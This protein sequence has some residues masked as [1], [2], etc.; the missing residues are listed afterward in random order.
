MKDTQESKVKITKLPS[1]R[2]WWDTTKTK[3]ILKIETEYV[4]EYCQNNLVD[5]VAL[6]R[7]RMLQ[8]DFYC[9][10]RFKCEYCGAG[11][12]KKGKLPASFYPME[13]GYIYKCCACSENKPLQ[14][15]LKDKN[16]SLAKEHALERWHKKLTG[17]NFNCSC[18]TE[19]VARIKRQRREEYKRKEEELKKKNKLAYEKRMKIQK[20]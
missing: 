12:K 15:F 18:P 14:Q 8:G 7:G 16:P 10:P 4:M 6:D 11:N 13:V 1:Q 2:V 19:E 9:S 20:N 17:T 5:T 3:E